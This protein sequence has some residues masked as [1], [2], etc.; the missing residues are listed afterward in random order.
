MKE[1]GGAESCKTSCG[2]LGFRQYNQRCLSLTKQNPHRARCLSDNLKSKLIRVTII[3]D[4]FYTS[5]KRTR[6]EPQKTEF[7]KRS[8]QR[9]DLKSYERKR[10]KN[11][12]NTHP[13]LS[14][15]IVTFEV[16]LQPL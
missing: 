15:D 1:H 9:R 4:R 5:G 10:H 2:D 3:M 11:E 6:R 8:K 13:Y 14:T 12:L 16:I 7:R